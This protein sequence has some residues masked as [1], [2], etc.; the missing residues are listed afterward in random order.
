MYY[1]ILTE[2]EFLKPENILLGESGVSILGISILDDLL[3]SAN[4]PDSDRIGDHELTELLY[5][6][7]G[8][9]C[10]VFRTHLERNIDTVFGFITSAA[11]LCIGRRRK[12]RCVHEILLWSK[13]LIW[14]PRIAKKHRLKKKARS[15]TE[16]GTQL[17]TLRDRTRYNLLPKN[18]DHLLKVVPRSYRDQMRTL[19]D[20]FRAFLSM[21]T[22]WEPGDILV[23]TRCI[24]ASFSPNDVGYSRLENLGHITDKII[25]KRSDIVIS[26]EPDGEYD[27]IVVENEQGKFTRQV[28]TLY[29]PLARS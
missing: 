9:V 22:I 21:D 1:I 13:I 12:R 4:G 8:N 18:I 2:G 3:D 19:S 29:N 14:I 27:R 24:D 25:H 11:C 15:F 17:S 6:L 26:A 16:F 10:M 5:T 7:R 20:G 28:Y 23:P